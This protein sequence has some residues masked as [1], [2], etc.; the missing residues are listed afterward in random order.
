[1]LYD[2][3]ALPGKNP[4]RDAHDV[5]DK[6]VMAAYRFDGKKDLVAQVLAL[7]ATVAAH[8]KAG[9]A[10]TGPGVPAVIADKASV[11]SSGCAVNP[12]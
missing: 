8:I 4:L 7:N 5:L 6:A 11:V 1:V 2:T 3:L 10:I 12:E 9:K